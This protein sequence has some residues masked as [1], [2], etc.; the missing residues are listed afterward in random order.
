MKMRV[1]ILHIQ[2]MG[3]NFKAKSQAV[4]PYAYDLETRF[5]FIS[6]GKRDAIYSA[7]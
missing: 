7:M 2:R 4:F 1:A 6:S 5:P 3:H